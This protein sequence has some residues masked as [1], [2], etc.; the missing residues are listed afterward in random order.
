[1]GA[2]QNPQLAGWFIEEIPSFEMDD[3]RYPHDY[4]NPHIDGY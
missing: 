4:G 3:E 1:M 2:P